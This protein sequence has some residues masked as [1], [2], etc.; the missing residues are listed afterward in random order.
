MSA[1]FKQRSFTRTL[2]SYLMSHG[3]SLSLSYADFRDPQRRD[4]IAG[5]FVIAR[6]SFSSPSV[7]PHSL[8]LYFCTA[9]PLCCCASV[10]SNP[11]PLCPFAPLPLRPC[12][13]APSSLSA[14]V[15]L[16]RNTAVQA[17]V[18]YDGR[19]VLTGRYSWPANEKGGIQDVPGESVPDTHTEVVQ[20]AAH[21]DLTCALPTD[22]FRIPG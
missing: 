21:A 8:P 5:D 6:R 16:C 9:K 14:S 2:H 19:V 11:S 17:T 12:A 1:G 3:P 4:V 7:L 13:P 20:F 18:N 10:P 22:I 15:R